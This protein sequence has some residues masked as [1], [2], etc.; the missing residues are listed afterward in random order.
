MIL[1][2]RLDEIKAGFSAQVPDA[3]KAVM[4]DS[5]QRLID[6][7]QVEKV[8]QKGEPFPPFN[9]PNANGESQALASLS[10]GAL[11]LSFFRGF[12]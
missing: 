7:N 8:A 12:W 4:G 10:E 3:A 2:E 6:N 11:V 1:K 5:L 9:L